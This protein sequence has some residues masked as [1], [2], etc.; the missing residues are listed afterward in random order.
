[1][2]VFL[3]MSAASGS[4]TP[5]P[6]FR[7]TSGSGLSQNTKRFLIGAGILGLFLYF[8]PMHLRTPKRRVV[9]VALPS[10]PSVR[11]E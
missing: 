5:N 10:A 2:Q 7:G 6:T 3:A 8:D 1:M 4:S 9:E 11:R